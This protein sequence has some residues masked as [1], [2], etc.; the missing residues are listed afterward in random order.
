VITVLVAGASGDDQNKLLS[1]IAGGA[2]SVLASQDAPLESTFSPLVVDATVSDQPF[3]TVYDESGVV[4]H[5]TGV[6]DGHPL[7][8]PAAVV[9]EALGSGGSQTDVDGVRVQVRRWENPNLG[10]GVVAAAQSLRV[11]KEQVAGLTAFLVIFGIIA[12]IAAGIGAWFMSGRALR[13]LRML[14]ETT[15]EIGATGNLA[16]RLPSVPQ[17]DE[18]GA[19][20]DSFNTMLEGIETARRD[21]ELTIDAQK[22]FVADASHELRSPLT[23][24]RANAGFLSGN[25]DASEQDRAE[26]TRD[27]SDEADRMTLLINGLLALARGDAA[28]DG[29]EAHVPVDLSSVV[30]S[31][32]RRARNLNVETA[33]QIPDSCIVMGDRAQLA[34]LVWILVDNADKHGGNNVSIAVVERPGETQIIVKDDGPGI[35]T[36]DLTRVFDRFHRSDP[37]RSRPG[38]GLGLSIAQSIVLAHGGS[39]DVSNAITGGA[40]FIVRFPSDR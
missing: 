14:A 31:V 27:I 32:Q 24:I 19:L 23:S 28:T 20:V 33:V 34:G 9:A 8:L 18:V 1:G 30:R 4:L 29:G 35:P 10:R 25:P 39:I 13:P 37:T 5:S 22:R 2:A 6:I 17:D 12:L 21:R 3:T 7:D 11:A 26:A 38:Y 16:Q 15:D 36:G 40:V